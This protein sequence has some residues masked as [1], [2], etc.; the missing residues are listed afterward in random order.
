MACCPVN[1]LP[2]PLCLP[3]VAERR[4][5]PNSTQLVVH[6]ARDKG[7]VTKVSRVLHEASIAELKRCANPQFP[8]VWIRPGVLGQALRFGIPPS[9]TR[10]NI[11]K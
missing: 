9:L 1:S 7:P 2:C 11:R 10:D 3:Y 5:M 8:T 6:L 4:T